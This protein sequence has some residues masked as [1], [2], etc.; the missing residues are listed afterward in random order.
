MIIFKT[1]RGKERLSNPDMSMA[2]QDKILFLV[3]TII[4]HRANPWGFTTLLGIFCPSG[5]SG[6]EIPFILYS[7]LIFSFLPFSWQTEIQMSACLGMIWGLWASYF[8]SSHSLAT[9]PLSHMTYPIEKIFGRGLINM[10]HLPQNG[11]NNGYKWFVFLK[12]LWWKINSK[13]FRT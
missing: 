7:T 11:D 13:L 6:I 10:N 1:F 2:L 12:I 5:H 9:Q 4:Q 8:I 3:H